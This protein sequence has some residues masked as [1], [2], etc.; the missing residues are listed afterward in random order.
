MAAGDAIA[1]TWDVAALREI[2]AAERAGL[3]GTS[4]NAEANAGM[5][6]AHQTVD[7]VGVVV[8]R[9]SASERLPDPGA[10]SV[11]VRMGLAL[12][13]RVLGPVERRRKSAQ[14]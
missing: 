12:Q 3:V 9:Q 14:A 6:Q 2:L 8:E 1:A 10:G 5:A 4:A 7:P 11:E 13:C